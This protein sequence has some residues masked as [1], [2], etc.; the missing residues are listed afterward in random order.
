[1][2]SSIISLPPNVAIFRKDPVREKLTRRDII[3]IRD[4]TDGLPYQEP[5]FRTI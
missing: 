3:D 1:M 5:A 2:N 4:E